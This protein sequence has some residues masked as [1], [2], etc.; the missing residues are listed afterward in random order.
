MQPVSEDGEEEVATSGTTTAT[1]TTVSPSKNNNK[2]TKKI[3]ISTVTATTKKINNNTTYMSKKNSSDEKKKKK[4]TPTKTMKTMKT[5]DSSSSVML[6]RTT[7]VTVF[8]PTLDARV[9]RIRH[10]GYIPGSIS[11]MAT[12]SSSSLSGNK[13]F[14]GEHVVAVARTDGSY[15]LKSI[16][17]SSGSSGSGN[18]KSNAAAPQH[19][20][21][22]IAETPPITGTKSS[23]LNNDNDDD[24]DDE[25]QS[26]SSQQC[27]D[28]ATSLCWVNPSSTS[29]SSKLSPACVGSGPNGNLWIVNFHKSNGV[30]RIQV[31]RLRIHSE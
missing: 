2:K 8:K 3:K 17:D 21:I 26:S 22:T 12:S 23:S 10:M 4:V 30:L 27:Y 19:R 14:G 31:F 7:K 28:A 16:I 6:K 1:T 18:N 5:I 20:L 24:D 25:Q 29:K 13:S 15:E 9:H 11:A